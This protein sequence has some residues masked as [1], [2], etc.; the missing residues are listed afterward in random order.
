ATSSRRL[1]APV[2]LLAI[3][4]AELDAAAFLHVVAGVHRQ[5]AD[6]VALDDRLAAEPRVD[7][8]VPCRVEPIGL[9]VLHLAQVLRA[10]PDDDVA[11]RA[12]AAGGAGVLEAEIEMLRHVEKR[13]RLA[14]VR[15]RELAVL[16]LHR[17]FFAVD[18]E[19]DLGHVRC[20]RRSAPT[21]RPAPSGS[22]PPPPG[23]W[24]LR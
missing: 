8:E 5:L 11:G 15:V 12:G 7:R 21:T 17:L 23:A 10:F 6:D 14:V 24:S 9:V 2:I 19:G 20:R 4:L 13:F 1:P 22:S 18:D 16:E 3:R